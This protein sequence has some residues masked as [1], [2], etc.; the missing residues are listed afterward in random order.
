MDFLKGMAGM[1]FMKSPGRRFSVSSPAISFRAQ[2]YS[3]F[4]VTT[5][6]RS[7]NSNPC[8]RAKPMAALVGLPFSSTATFLAGPSFSTI[9]SSCLSATSATQ[10]QSLLGVAMVLVSPCRILRLANSRRIMSAMSFWTPGKKAAG[11]SSVPI[12]S[13]SSLP[14][15]N[16]RFVDLICDCIRNRR[17]SRF[18]AAFAGPFPTHPCYFFSSG[19]PISSR[20]LRY[21]SALSRARFRT[22]PM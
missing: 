3:P 14:I 5:V 15:Q 13:S 20:C 21:P 2:R 7:E 18:P 17:Q 10:R 4:S 19:K 16:H 8:P 11:I 22:L 6:W 1:K 12:S 9:W